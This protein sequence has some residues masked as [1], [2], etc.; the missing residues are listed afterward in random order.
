MSNDP[1]N[2][3]AH[4]QFS[5]DLMT[6]QAEIAETYPPRAAFMIWNSLKYIARAMRKGK[7]VE[8]LRKAEHYLKR[9]IELMGAKND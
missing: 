6:V 8:D 7:A 9:A 2:K 1:V 5:F 3:P 4:Y